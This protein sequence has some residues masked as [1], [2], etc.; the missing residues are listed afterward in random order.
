MYL[1]V[2]ILHKFIIVE[3][4]HIAEAVLKHRD[5]NYTFY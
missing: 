4:Q 5:D 3:I 2:L 1:V